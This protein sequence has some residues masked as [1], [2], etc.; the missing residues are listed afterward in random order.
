MEKSSEGILGKFY[1]MPRFGP[2]IFSAFLFLLL[3]LFQ[4]KL[5][6][7]VQQFL[8]PALLLYSVGS[9]VISYVHRLMGL[10][11]EPEIMHEEIKT[12]TNEDGNKVTRLVIKRANN[13]KPIPKGWKA[14]FYLSQIIWFGAFVYYMFSKVIL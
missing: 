11:Y 7:E 13:E 1:N 12:E 6:P 9:A 14:A 3:L 4:G 8:L 10:N 5:R 2:A